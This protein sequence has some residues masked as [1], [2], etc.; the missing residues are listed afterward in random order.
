MRQREQGAQEPPAAS[1]GDWAE[2]SAGGGN[3]AA[4]QRLILHPK[5]V[6]AV[7][8]LRCS[9]RWFTGFPQRILND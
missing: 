3:S 5:R 4:Y 2:W 8:N 7:I 9:R 1:S 6:T